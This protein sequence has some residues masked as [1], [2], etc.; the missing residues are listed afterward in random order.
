MQKPELKFTLFY[1]YCLLR[2]IL[3]LCGINKILPQNRSCNFVPCQNYIYFNKPNL[4][5]PVNPNFKS[6]LH[7]NS[8]CSN[9]LTTAFF[10]WD[11]LL[12]FGFLGGDGFWVLRWDVCFWFRFFLLKELQIGCHVF[13][14][15]SWLY[16]KHPPD[17][18]KR[19]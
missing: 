3:Q 13:S 2:K 19:V 12:W 4:T 9:K 7:N 18:A 8:S 10:C 15:Y 16:P 11:F 1:N 14:N 17:V 6:V 5:S